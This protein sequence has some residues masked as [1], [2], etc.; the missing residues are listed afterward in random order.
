MRIPR[1][2]W[3]LLIPVLLVVFAVAVRVQPTD[4]DITQLADRVELEF[5]TDDETISAAT[6]GQA[7][8]LTAEKFQALEFLI[9]AG[10]GA[11][12]STSTSPI[13]IRQEVTVTG[14][15]IA[16]IGTATSPLIL[17]ALPSSSIATGTAAVMEQILVT[18]LG[19]PIQFNPEWNLDPDG[20]LCPRG[21]STCQARL[22]LGL[23][24]SDP[25]AGG[26]SNSLLLTD[27]SSSGTPL[28]G[29]AWRADIDCTDWTTDPAQYFNCRQVWA[30]GWFVGDGVRHDLV[31]PSSKL[32]DPRQGIYLAGGW[33][34]TAA[35][36]TDPGQYADQA[37]RATAAQEMWLEAFAALGDEKT[38]LFRFIFTYRLFQLN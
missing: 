17:F 36:G 12:G 8:V 31:E 35:L 24:S 4:V 38:A 1:T 29:A 11:G 26:A 23:T 6:A 14:P 34:S 21:R 22:V 3:L 28:D 13:A 20:N 16:N 30:D 18:R 10:P 5:G 32:F 25:T 7:G 19:D 37:A 2:A 15:Q 27:Y 33:A 9:A